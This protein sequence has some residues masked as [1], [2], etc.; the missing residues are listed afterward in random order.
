MTY[1]IPNG[2]ATVFQTRIHHF[3]DR[4]K[5]PRLVEC[6]SSRMVVVCA[7]W[8]EIRDVLAN[9]GSMKLAAYL[10]AGACWPEGVI[11]RCY[12]G[13]TSDLVT[14]LKNHAGDPNKR[15]VSEAFVI[16]SRYEGF[17]KIDVQLLQYHLNAWI[18]KLDRAYIVRGA[19]PV[20][21]KV[22]T[23][24]QIRSERDLDDVRRLLPSIG[25]N[26]QEARDDGFARENAQRH[27]SPPNGVDRSIAADLGVET[28][29]T[30]WWGE[31]QRTDCAPVANAKDACRKEPN[32]AR[33]SPRPSLFVL[34][35]AGLSASGYQ[36]GAE[37]VVLPG[38]Q[39]RRS[40]QNS[41]RDGFKEGASNRQRRRD[42]EQ[43]Q[44]IAKVDGYGDRWRLTKERRFPS[45]G[46][47]AS[48]L[49]GV[50]LAKDSWVE[51]RRGPEQ[52]EPNHERILRREDATSALARHSEGASD[53][54]RQLP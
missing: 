1:L 9:L 50:N 20:L 28:A 26:F 24:R 10:L 12:V 23:S 4:P 41:F 32:V 52:P 44:V 25:C 2:S 27:R 18:E 48:V 14:R 17:D 19:R 3:S 42:I 45:R 40:E 36:D 16:G 5:G 49:M 51:I 37:F 43:S 30:A 21:P 13:E 29:S 31:D 53:D 46:I 6:P 34:N 8:C 15:F 39:M 47:A 7:P 54:Q 33:A 22:D 38:S 35:H 11:G